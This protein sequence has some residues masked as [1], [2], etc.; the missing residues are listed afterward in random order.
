MDKLP[1]KPKLT[2][3]QEELN[4]L[5]Q[6]EFFSYYNILGANE[7]LQ[8]DEIFF[9]WTTPKLKQKF[10]ETIQKSYSESFIEGLKFEYGVE[11]YPQDFKRA[12]QIY[13]DAADN[14]PD[15]LS[16][17][18]MYVIHLKDF[19]K[20]NIKQDR[21]LENY[22]LFKCMT[23]TDFSVMEQSE[24]LYNSI[25]P[26]YE[27][28]V[29]IHQEDSNGVKFNKMI[30]L[31]KNNKDY[32]FHLKDLLL[33]KYC[34]NYHFDWS[35]E[36]LN[37]DLESLCF[38]HTDEAL[39]KLAYFCQLDKR[40]YHFFL[41]KC[42]EKKYYKAYYA[43]GENYYTNK[44]MKEK[45]EKIFRE[46]ALHY[47]RCGIPY[48]NVIKYK[49]DYENLKTNKALQKELID[50]M[51]YDLTNFLMGS[52]YRLYEFLYITKVLIRH[53]NLKIEILEKYLPLMQELIFFVYSSIDNE[54][55]IN[56]SFGNT[57]AYIEMVF[58]LSMFLI[59]DLGVS[60]PFSSF[61][62]Y[63]KLQLLEKDS[64]AVSNKQS[65]QS[66]IYKIGKQLLKEKIITQERLDT[67][68]KEVYNLTE[69]YIQ[70]SKINAPSALYLLGKICED[71]KIR[72]KD[73][74]AAFIYYKSATLSPND[75][76][77][78][79]PTSFSYHKYKCQLKIQSDVFQRI[80][81]SLFDNYHISKD[82]DKICFICN[83]KEKNTILLPCFHQMCSD[84]YAHIK[85]TAN[86]CPFCRGKILMD[87]I[88]E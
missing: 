87:K 55:F 5:Y 45:G 6:I 10:Q 72:H 74:N 46:G 4:N 7:T 26:V 51:E 58:S 60:T 66:L 3:V 76:T 48:S 21:V 64:K 25:D 84:C 13:K 30:R 67:I 15:T 81:I 50:S 79:S 47:Y 41:E 69:Q 31:L 42:Y 80:A 62:C 54:S 12:Y 86:K 40:L 57:Y 20:F 70:E 23:Y 78:Y 82:D 83:D 37:K 38:V 59:Y 33:I 1:S 14:T 22:Y 71:G 77:F 52:I 11:G 16:M 27:A 35:I 49:V 39:Y 75:I 18:R 61:E 9:K 65:Y 43:L 44:Q 2:K 19:D 85:K 68:E 63:N 24:C 53:Y 28:E 17:Y 32:G 88:M 8:W 73:N 56:S 36:T 29:H 34:V